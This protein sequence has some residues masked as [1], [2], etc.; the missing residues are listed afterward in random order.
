MSDPTDWCD[1]LRDV[2]KREAA[3]QLVRQAAD[4]WAKADANALAP[5]V[6]AAVFVRILAS[7]PRVEPMPPMQASTLVGEYVDLP[8]RPLEQ[9]ATLVTEPSEE[10]A[11][12]V[13]KPAGPSAERASSQLVRILASAAR[14]WQQGDPE[15]PPTEEVCRALVRTLFDEKLLPWWTRTPGARP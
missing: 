11:R 15:S 14:S 1:M 2:A 9:W 8:L 12:L 3:L 10:C 5:P 6:V 7:R 13:P 4:S